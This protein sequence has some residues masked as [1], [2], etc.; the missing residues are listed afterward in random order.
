MHEVICNG[1]R[2]LIVAARWRLKLEN[3][4]HAVTTYVESHL[5]DHGRAPPC[6]VIRNGYLVQRTIQTDIGDIQ[7][8]VL[9]VTGIASGNRIY[10]KAR[11]YY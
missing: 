10:F 9:K 4:C 3:V 1:D 7:I 8:K 11:C 6:S 5:V 2:K